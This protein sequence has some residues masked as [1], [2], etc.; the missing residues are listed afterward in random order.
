MKLCL[1]ENCE[2]SITAKGL[3]AKHYGY[4]RKGLTIE[5]VLEGVKPPKKVICNFKGCK[6]EVVNDSLM[7]NN[8]LL[9]IKR[10]ERRN[11]LAI[12]G[13]CKFEGC[14]NY[15]KNGIVCKIHEPELRRLAS[16]SDI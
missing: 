9:E 15:P 13:K 14:T 12:K 8:H 5:Q 1:V 4:T 7:C 2:K 6:E 16:I 3:C 10:V 11:E